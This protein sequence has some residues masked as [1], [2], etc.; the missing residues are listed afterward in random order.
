MRLGSTRQLGD[1]RQPKSDLEVERKEEKTR[2]R[3][4]VLQN[5]AVWADVLAAVDY[6]E[7]LAIIALVA[8]LALDRF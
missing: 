3:L 5:R 6:R 7:I 2:H 1:N 4:F 8:R